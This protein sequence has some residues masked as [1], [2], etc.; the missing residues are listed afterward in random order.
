LL[1]F[2]LRVI[3]P[4]IYHPEQTDSFLQILGLQMAEQK[5]DIASLKAR[6]AVLEEAFYRCVTFIIAQNIDKPGAYALLPDMIRGL[7]VAAVDKLPIANNML[8]CILHPDPTL[9]RTVLRSGL[10]VGEL[11]DAQGKPMLL[12]LGEA[13]ANS[14]DA[15]EILLV[16]RFKEI[17]RAFEGT[18]PDK[19]ALVGQIQILR[20]NKI[21]E[22]VRTPN[23]RNCDNQ[24]AAMDELISFLQEA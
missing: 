3:F 20:A 13:V 17:F 18:H 19:A 4:L 8:T 7:P 1:S 2:Y 12:V 11:K 24:I 15:N 16:A 21:A 14:T 22:R 23:A 5:D 9:M 10:H 6:I